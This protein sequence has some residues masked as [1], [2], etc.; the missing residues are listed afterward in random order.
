MQRI[1]SDSWMIIRDRD[2]GLIVVDDIFTRAHPVY[3]LKH[4]A[5]NVKRV[6]TFAS[7]LLRGDLKGVLVRSGL[8][9]V[10]EPVGV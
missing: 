5:E 3:C 10:L 9:V 7:L 2:K 8:Y 4:L 1:N 6:K